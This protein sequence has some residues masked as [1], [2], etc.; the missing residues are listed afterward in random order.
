[1]AERVADFDEV[2]P[3]PARILIGGRVRTFVGPFA[4]TRLAG[5][6]ARL[7]GVET[8]LDER[9]RRGRPLRDA[10]GGRRGERH[11]A[12]QRIDGQ[13]I[14]AGKRFIAQQVARLVARLDPLLDVERQDFRLLLGLDPKQIR[15]GEF[16]V[17]VTHAVLDDMIGEALDPAHQRRQPLGQRR[18]LRRL[19]GGAV[20]LAGERGRRQ[21]E[22][23]AHDARQ[24]LVKLVLVGRLLRRLL[25]RV[26][27]VQF[28]QKTIS[29][30]LTHFFDLLKK[31]RV[32][33]TEPRQSNKSDPAV[34]TNQ[35]FQSIPAAGRIGI[36]SKN[37]RVYAHVRVWVFC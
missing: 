16:E 33:V 7:V 6:D 15:P 22:G 5:G 31:V 1:M 28:P 8:V 10:S 29:A 13:M 37:R 23:V 35:G 12:L 18:L 20:D 32:F 9:R 3:E 24:P 34:L 11:R 30:K 17:G 4:T 14:A 19:G 25:R 36:V 26:A 2:R 27:P 21:R